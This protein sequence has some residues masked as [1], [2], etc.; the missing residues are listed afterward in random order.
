MSESEYDSKEGKEWHPL[1]PLNER[2]EAIEVD[3]NGVKAAVNDLKTA[4]NKMTRQYSETLLSLMRTVACLK[5]DN[6]TR[7]IHSILNHQF[8][9]KSTLVTQLFTNASAAKSGTD[10]SNH[11]FKL[12]SDFH[13]KWG[14]K[15]KDLGADVLQF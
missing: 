11:P 4:H 7:A 2:I 15:L 14:K 10:S 9:N 13:E 1:H 12:S 3:L 6:E 8:P 5:I